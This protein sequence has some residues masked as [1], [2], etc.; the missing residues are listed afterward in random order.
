MDFS[1]EYAYISQLFLH[2]K[3][4]NEQDNAKNIFL[5]AFLFRK[6]TFRHCNFDDQYLSKYC[7]NI[8]F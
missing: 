7:P 8:R 3:L 5:I 4:V 6:I 1:I 2:D